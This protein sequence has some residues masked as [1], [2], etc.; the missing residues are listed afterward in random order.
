MHWLFLSISALIA[1]AAAGEP[2]D[3][4]GSLPEPSAE[5]LL[6]DIPFEPDTPPNRVVI[7]LAPEGNR[8]LVM[9]L[10]T[11]ATYSIITPRVARELGISVRRTKSS[12]YRRK[13]RVGR[14]VQFWIDD[15][16]S[17]TGSSFGFEVGLLGANFLE[18]FVVELD[19]EGRRVR[20]F[21]AK[22]YRLP[23]SVESPDETV[24]P[25]RVVS[26]R[27][28]PEIEMNGRKLHV[29]LDTGAHD[30]LILSGKAARKL[31]VNP[32][33]LPPFGEFNTVKGPMP[34]NL[35]ET[36]TFALGPFGFDTM[37]VFV[38]PRGWYNQAG[39]N[40][41]V[42]GYD[43]LRQFTIRI[44]YKRKR[45]WLRR[46]RDDVTF[47]GVDYALTR[48]SGAFLWPAGRT[49]LVLGVVP[50]SPADRIGLR[51]GDYF[52]KIGGTQRGELS[53]ILARIVDGKEI[54]VARRSKGDIMVDISL[55]E[56]AA[57]DASSITFDDD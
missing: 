57:I 34:V 4:P 26:G 49:H 35:Y 33:E 48:E 45:M 10:D 47:M 41:S 46:E 27:I 54:L 28:F 1:G 39:T 8:P 42:L 20:F 37:P 51:P 56:D 38:A 6:A 31:G 43:T 16:L 2:A 14:D 13:T 9:L 22:K 32:K 18:Q 19:F 24:M 55:P 5:A 44:D 21:D 40:D 23:E 30:S 11:G 15:R 25:V 36:D 53:E 52:T 3:A 50:D 29:C 7:N 12:P 17:D